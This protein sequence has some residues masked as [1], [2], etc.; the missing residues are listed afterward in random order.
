M[1]HDRP[2]VGVA[3]LSTKGDSSPPGLGHPLGMPLDEALMADRILRDELWQSERFLDLPTD[4]ARL[5]FL[6]FLSLADDFGNFEGGPRRLHR[7]LNECTLLKTADASSGAIDA[8]MGADLIRRYSIEDRELFH[9]PRFKS[10]KQYLAR[11][12]PA[13]PW[14]LKNEVLGKDRRVKNQGLAKD[15]VTTSLLH[16]SLVAEGVG[17]GVRDGAG[18][19]AGDGGEKQ[20]T[21][22]PQVAVSTLEIG[23]ASCRE[24]VS[25]PV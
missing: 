23:R 12:Y 22:V 19:G 13:S 2:R 16:S 9:I 4:I 20:P 17:D 18:D 24:R 1:A 15:V 5:A 7:I 10:H 25:S 11:R 3:P 6:R 21:V 8:L 14:C